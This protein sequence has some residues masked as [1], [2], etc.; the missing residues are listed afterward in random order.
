LVLSSNLTHI[1]HTKQN[2]A[3]STQ[4]APGI[5]SPSIIKTVG[6]TFSTDD[7][8]VT[9]WTCRYYV[10]SKEDY[11]NAGAEAPVEG[12]VETN[13]QGTDQKG[14]GEDGGKE[15]MIVT[16]TYEGI[17][18]DSFAGINNARIEFDASFGEEP[19]EAHPDWLDIK[20]LFDGEHDEE[21]GK[22]T[23]RETL[24]DTAD[25]TRVAGIASA[26]GLSATVNPST[27]KKE[28]KNPLFGEETFLSLGAVFRRTYAV[29]EIP[30]YILNL[31]GTVYPKLPKE[32]KNLDLPGGERNWM[33]QP[34]KLTRRGGAYVITDEWLQSPIGGWNE[35]L[36]RSLTAAR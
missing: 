32:F 16:V 19:L 3:M 1:Y 33:Q 12:L 2:H 27:G 18:D 17:V 30:D 29:S 10:A 24:T 21:T 28:L 22:V 9:T 20:V 23:F 36:Y 35:A 15:G 11:H 13:R 4:Y 6:Q 7:I 25:V 34:F 14:L 26:Y 31:I 5:G 8:G